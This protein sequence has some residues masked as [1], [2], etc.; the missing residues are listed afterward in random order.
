M[1]ESTLC[2]FPIILRI[3]LHE[4]L[5]SGLFLLRMNVISVINRPFAYQKQ[6]LLLGYGD[7]LFEKISAEPAPQLI[8]DFI[9]VSIVVLVC[10]TLSS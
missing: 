4:V 3:F 9:P 1:I 5:A 7:F 6:I 10:N 8:I 2:T